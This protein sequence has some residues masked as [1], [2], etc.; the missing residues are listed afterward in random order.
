MIQG[1]YGNQRPLSATWTVTGSAAFLVASDCTKKAKAKMPAT[2]MLH[3]L[4]DR[5]H[6][7]HA[8]YNPIWGV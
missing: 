8:P 4:M 1:S 3:T 5:P 7:E 6:V 2:A